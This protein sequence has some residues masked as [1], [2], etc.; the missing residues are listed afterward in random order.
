MTCLYLYGY[1]NLGSENYLSKTRQKFAP[2]FF[3]TVCFYIFVNV[4][5]KISIVHFNLRFLYLK[6]S[7]RKHY[8]ISIS[9]FIHIDKSEI[10]QIKR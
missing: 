4:N 6:E 10:S 8:S 9:D 7:N 2:H 3:Y 5:V 1:E